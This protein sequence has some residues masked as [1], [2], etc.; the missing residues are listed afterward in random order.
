ML[1]CCSVSV[2]RGF[3]SD[4]LAYIQ[5]VTERS[6]PFAPNARYARLKALEV[7]QRSI[8]TPPHL[9]LRPREHLPHDLGKPPKK[10]IC[11]LHT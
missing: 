3:I 10:T 11:Q 7:T 5:Y 2:A 8:N 1:A 9:P 6:P 4:P